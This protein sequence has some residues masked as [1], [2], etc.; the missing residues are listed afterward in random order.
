MNSARRSEPAPEPAGAPPAPVEPPKRCRSR[1]AARRPAARRPAARRRPP[2]TTA[3]S[4]AAAALAAALAVLALALTACS[5]TAPPARL[6][7]AATP[8]ATLAPELQPTAQAA[9]LAAEQTR[10]AAEARATALAVDALAATAT[11][12]ALAAA[13]EA[14]QTV[15]SAEL[16]SLRIAATVQ[17]EQRRAR[18]DARFAPLAQGGALAG[19]A[20]AAGLALAL[21]GY[22]ALRFIRTEDLRRRV[23]RGADG[24]MILLDRRGRGPA[25]VMPG[26]NF[27]PVTDAESGPRDV[28]LSYYDAANARYQA[29]KAVAA[30]SRGERPPARDLARDL[31]GVV[32]L[33]SA[34]ADGAAQSLEVTI[35]GGTGDPPELPAGVSPLLLEA[36]E[37]DWLRPAG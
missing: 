1:P 16:A 24:D 30:A 15:E 19:A 7:L 11:R 25:I 32:S 3:A 13:V 31:P 21:A 8:A 22:A 4:L 28:P 34:P 2:T 14:R 12:G 17:A 26:R 6:A 20:L 29:V 33:L 10:V 35:I 9:Q 5:P 27:S 36:A 18:W 23:I 37:R